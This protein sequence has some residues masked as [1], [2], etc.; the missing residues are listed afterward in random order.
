[1]VITELALWK[2]DILNKSRTVTVL[3]DKTA[4]SI[5]QYNQGYSFEESLEYIP[6]WLI[7]QNNFS[8]FHNTIAL[9]NIKFKNH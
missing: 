2:L 5:D 1:M 6:S 9:F 8:H 7:L 4:T 3:I